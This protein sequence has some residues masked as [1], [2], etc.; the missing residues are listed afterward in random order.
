MK[1]MQIYT[2]TD[3]YGKETR[4]DQVCTILG[5]TIGLKDTIMTA[6]LIFFMCDQ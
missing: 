3:I 1:R 4:P 6:L 2:H 5:I